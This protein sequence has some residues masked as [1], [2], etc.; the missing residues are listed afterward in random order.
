[1]SGLIKSA[2]ELKVARLLEKC[3]DLKSADKAV[4]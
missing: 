4:K 2:F 1:M 3:A